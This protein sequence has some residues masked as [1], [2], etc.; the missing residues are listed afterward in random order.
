M[1]AFIKKT[2]HY[3]FISYV[4]HPLGF[5]WCDKCNRL[6]RWD[7]QISIQP[8]L[9]GRKIKMKVPYCTRCITIKMANEKKI[10][11]PYRKKTIKNV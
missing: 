2:F 3:L 10:I 6:T 8:S 1:K 9:D 4:L 5:Y 11:K 7:Y